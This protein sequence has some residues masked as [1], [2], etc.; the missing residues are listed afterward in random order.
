MA[1][2]HKHKDPGKEH[3]KESTPLVFWGEI[4]PSNHILQ[5]YEN[6]EVILSS[7]E[8]YVTAGFDRNESVII[9]ATDDHISGLNK[10]LAAAGYDLQKLEKNERYLTVNAHT[11]LDQFMVNNWPDETQFVSVVSD[12]ISRA[13]G[14]NNRNIR[15]YGEMVAILWASGN[16]GATVNLEKLWNNFCAKKDFSLFC[17]YPRA[18]F[19]QEVQD[20][21]YKICSHHTKLVV[22]G[23]NNKSGIFYI[24]M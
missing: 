22:S 6:D 3:W 2:E 23:E 12:L 19:T 8:G 13:R 24:D 17:A 10:R 15:A 7:L 18:G 14:K 4:A 1:T 5:I 16:N 21:I 11:V 9:I 20:S